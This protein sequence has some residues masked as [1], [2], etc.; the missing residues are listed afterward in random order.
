MSEFTLG[1]ILK[2]LKDIEPRLQKIDQVSEKVDKVAE[3]DHF[4]AITKAHPDWRDIRDSGKLQKFI[5]AQP[6]FVRSSLER[7]MK[8]G[9]SDEVIEMFDAYKESMGLASSTKT[10][11]GRSK[12]KKLKDMSAVDGSSGGPPKDKT[13]IDKDDFD[14]AWEDAVSKD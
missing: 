6:S 5:D 9:D 10:K 11:G 2:E 7:V 3:E 14:A 12:D 8:E 4:D 1:S 13:K